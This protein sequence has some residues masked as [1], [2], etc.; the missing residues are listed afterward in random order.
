MNH[1]AQRGEPITQTDENLVW[2]RVSPLGRK[3]PS[4]GGKT[5]SS[6]F[7]PGADPGMYREAQMLKFEVRP[8]MPFHTKASKPTHV[9]KAMRVGKRC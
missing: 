7:I 5:C 2:M 6:G 9:E 3:K 1:V 8:K 4:S